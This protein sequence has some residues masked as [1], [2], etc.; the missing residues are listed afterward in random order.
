[1]KKLITI[2]LALALI[3]P[4]STLA[5]DKEVSEFFGYAHINTEKDGAPYMSMIY[6]CKDQTCYYYTQMFHAGETGFGRAY[7]GIWGYTA[8]GDVFAKVGNSD[9][10]KIVFAITESG[11]IVDRASMDVFEP[12]S[13]RLD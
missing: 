3:L 2:I 1:M 8:D 12:I 10:A 7:V 4:V 13:A 9:S 6:F 11:A 5:V